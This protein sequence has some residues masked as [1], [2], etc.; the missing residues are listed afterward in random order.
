MARKSS[1]RTELFKALT[2]SASIASAQAVLDKFDSLY[3]LTVIYLDEKQE[4][5]LRAD[6]LLRHLRERRNDFVASFCPEALA[7]LKDVKEF[8]LSDLPR[9]IDAL[10]KT[11]MIHRVFPVTGK[12]TSGT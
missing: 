1:L 5:K 3:Y 8:S 4:R 10:R 6:E 12:A 9:A 7:F 11:S 2:I